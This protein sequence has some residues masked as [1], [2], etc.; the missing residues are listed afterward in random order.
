MKF[1][2]KVSLASPVD[3]AAEELKKYL[4]MMMPEG[5]D[6]KIEYAPNAKD[7]FRLGLMA[8]FGLDI[9]DGENPELDDVIYI[10]TD[11]DGG[12]IAG[13]NPRAVLIAVYE[14]LR[15]NGCEWLMPGV[16]G[17]IVPIGDVVPVKLR[18]TP[19][20]RVRG[21]CIEGGVSQKVLREFID[22]MPKL[23]LNCFM[24]QFQNPKEFYQRFYAH[25]RNEENRPC[26]PITDAT[27]IQWTRAL[28][29][30]MDKR[31]ISLHSVG[32]GWTNDPYGIDSTLCWA[33]VDDSV[34]PEK[35][36]Q[37]MALYKGKRGFYRG[38]PA[39]TQI[40]MSNPEARRLFVNCVADY[41]DS[42]SN[43]GYLHVWLADDSNNHCECDACRKKRS[44]DWY[45][46][47]LNEIDEELTRRGNT[48]KI[49]L[50]VYVDLCWPPI[51]EKIKNPER[52]L[53]MLAPITRDY[54]VTLAGCS[55]LEMKP[56][57]LNKLEM[58]GPLDE[59]L[60]YAEAWKKPCK[61]DTFA[62]EY[63]FWKHH[64]YDLSG[65]Q[66][67]KRIYE[68]TL[69]YLEH[70]VSG[71][72]QCGSQRGF[73]PNGFA[74]YVHARAQFDISTSYDELL[75]EY[76][77]AAYG[78]GWESFNSALKKLSDAVPYEYLAQPKAA[79]RPKAYHYP[80]MKPGIESLF[81]ICDELDGLVK[82]HYNSP[83]RAQTVVIRILERYIRFVRDLAAAL[84]YKCVG[85]NERS[86]EEYEKLRLAL[87]EDECA[88]E[89]YDDYVQRSGFTKYMML[90]NAPE[91]INNAN[92]E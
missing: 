87:G 85:E 56:Y 7:G 10:D 29:C 36:L 2:Y 3:Y 28:E 63:H 5:G 12:I 14:Y 16:D 27:A 37:Y 90:Y 52:F 48:V 80:E 38:R 91:V 75:R 4:R 67:A 62:F 32:H 89:L 86:V 60:V 18:H 81:G 45:V 47:L 6:I 20:M 51:E 74:F 50:A 49:V 61:S 17:E 68:D 59:Y 22:F 40:C 25:L 65:L 42:H 88:F 71:I 70:G 9:L 58:P 64:Q 35:S 83:L 43:T 53:K 39:N 8:D 78:E 72:M 84:S 77:S 33:E 30:E 73:T 41:A 57:V 76:Y 46:I 26:E 79:E 11:R 82:E 19:T 31:G 24:I 54:S 55:E 21:N 92:G 15:R 44:S 66:M 23:G 1:I 34:I 13:S 69:C